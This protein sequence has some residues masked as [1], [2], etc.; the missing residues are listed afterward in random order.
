MY[1]DTPAN[2]PAANDSSDNGSENFSLDSG[3]LDMTYQTMYP[4]RK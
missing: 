4:K 2:G 1:R 3:I